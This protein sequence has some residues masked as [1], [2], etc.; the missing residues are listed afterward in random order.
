MLGD[1]TKYLGCRKPHCPKKTMADIGSPMLA[2]I[3]EIENK[4]KEK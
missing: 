1:I 3:K 4:P 2:I